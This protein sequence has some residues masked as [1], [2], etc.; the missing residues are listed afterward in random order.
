MIE[1]AIHKELQDLKETG[2]FRK[3]LLMNSKEDF[4]KVMKITVADRTAE[5][6]FRPVAIPKGRGVTQ[7][8]RDMAAWIAG[9]SE[10]DRSRILW[11]M[12]DCVEA[13]LFGVFCVLDGVRSIEN[14]DKK[15]RLEL[16][17]T[18]PDGADTPLNDDHG[19]FL[20]D[21]FKSLT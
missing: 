9:L 15:G 1:T 11:L 3:C 19:E 21:I 12:N 20:H 7:E 8:Q 4:V 13:T 16:R 10:A 17:Y 2:R 5:G 14:I 18:A 6:I